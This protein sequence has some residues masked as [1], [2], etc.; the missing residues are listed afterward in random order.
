MTGLATPLI[1]RADFKDA[2]LLAELGARTFSETFADDNKSEDMAA[3]LAASFSHAKQTEEL[4]DALSLYLIAEIDNEA[5]AYAQLY[6]G[7]APECV[8]G[9]APIELV[10]F[11]VTRKWHGR[12][13][14]ASL[15]R[16]CIDEARR[17]GR[18]TMWLGVWEHNGRAQAFYRKWSFQKVGEH[19]FQLGSDPQNDVLMAM[20]IEGDAHTDPGL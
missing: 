19:I 18:R 2:G 5:V 13:V 10:R 16:A 7:V 9:D 14:S 6:A 4:L 15:M 1:R 20:K 12:G 17:A 3:Y 11:Y 8:T